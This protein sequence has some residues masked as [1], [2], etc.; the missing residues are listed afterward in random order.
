[1]ISTIGGSKTTVAASVLLRIRHGRLGGVDSKAAFLSARFQSSDSKAS[2]VAKITP[3]NNDSIYVI[4]VPITN[5]KSYIFCNHRPSLLDKS[6]LQAIPWLTKI[7]TKATGLVTKGWKKLTDS[8][9]SVNVKVVTFVK[10]MLDTIPYEENCLKS[11]PSQKLM[12]R[13]VNEESMDLLKAKTTSAALIQSQIDDLQIPPNQIKPIP[14]Y[15]PVFQ[16]PSAILNQLYLFRDVAYSKHLKYATLCG[17]GIPVSL[18]FALLPVLPNVPGFYLAYRLYCNVKALMGVKHL[19]YLLKDC[20]HPDAKSPQVA[21]EKDVVDTKH[22]AF[23]AVEALDELYRDI[24]GFDA[25]SPATQEK[26][27]VSKDLI[28]NFCRKFDLPHL[29]EDLL[30]ALRQESV[31]LQKALSPSLDAS[32]SESSQ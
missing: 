9:N 21:T 22:L 10:K 19:D 14:L 16:Q 17:I 11:F 26:V 30:K 25:P 18:P 8:D 7:E 23:T 2:K 20:S 5:Y 29:R 3:I 28:E 6:Q 15:H 4:A 27:I 13:E 1:M 31:R 24:P 12:I 32:L